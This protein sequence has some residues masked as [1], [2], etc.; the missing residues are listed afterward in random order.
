MS[1]RM[2]ADLRQGA[3]ASGGSSVRAQ[4]EYN[5]MPGR[6]RMMNPGLYL[7]G[8]DCNSQHELANDT[9]RWG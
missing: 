2:K 9:G 7:C 1:L 5:Q 4:V 3:V 6:V 8:P